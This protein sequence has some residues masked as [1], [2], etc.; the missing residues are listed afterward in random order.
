MLK[1]VFC[2]RKRQDISDEEFYDYWLNRHGPLV[3]SKASSLNIRRYVQSHT[4]D[5][6]FGQMIASGRGMK[7]P[8]FDGIAEVWWNDR[9]DVDM[10]LETEEGQS[11]SATL[12]EDE[13]RFIDMANSTI[14]FTNEHSLVES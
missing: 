4:T 3:A 12:A 7:V 8:S 10:A 2:V 1:M 14:F 5:N 6:Q 9:K 11:S 13:A